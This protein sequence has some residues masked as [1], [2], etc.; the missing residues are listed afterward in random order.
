MCVRSPIIQL[1]GRV[2]EIVGFWQ[3]L[4][5]HGPLQK[6]RSLDRTWYEIAF[7]AKKLGK[8][9]SIAQEN[10][11][12]LL[13]RGIGSLAL[14]TEDRLKQLHLTKDR[15]SLDW[16]DRP[17]ITLPLVSYPRRMRHPHSTRSGK[18]AAV[19][20]A[21]IEKKSIAIS[22][23]KECCADR[24][25]RKLNQWFHLRWITLIPVGAGSPTITANNLPSQKPAPTGI[26][27]LIDRTWYQSLIGI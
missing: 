26:L 14:Q 7:S 16:M 20:R 22:V 8:L 3:I 13:R 18:Y 2:F 5:A 12:I 4:L 24:P 23:P 11:Q 15:I 1:P 27:W 9:H 6:S 10:Q 21:F 19:V 25:I 17:T